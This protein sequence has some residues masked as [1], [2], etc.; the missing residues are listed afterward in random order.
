MIVALRLNKSARS[1]LQ[2]L[3]VLFKTPDRTNIVIVVLIVVVLVTI[4]E[5]LFPRIVVIVLRRTPIVVI[6][7]TANHI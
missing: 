2:A 4:V 6:S 1:K 7:K 5:I 3:V